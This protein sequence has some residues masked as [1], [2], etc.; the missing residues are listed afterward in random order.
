MWGGYSC[1][2][3]DSGPLFAGVMRMTWSFEAKGFGTLVS[4]RAQN[5]PEGIRAEYHEKAM[6]LHCNPPAR[7]ASCGEGLNPM[8]QGKKGSSSL[9]LRPSVPWTLLC[10]AWTRPASVESKS[11]RLNG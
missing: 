3:V 2:E 9:P 11:G 1:V 4:V 5:V 10:A 7:C 6:R 8:P